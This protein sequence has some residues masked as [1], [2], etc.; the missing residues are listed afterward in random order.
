MMMTS[1]LCRAA[2][3]N[4]LL[5]QDQVSTPSN[6]AKGSKT[7]GKQSYSRSKD[8]ARAQAWPPFRSKGGSLQS[9]NVKSSV[10]AQV[11]ELQR[12]IQLLGKMAAEGT[13][14]SGVHSAHAV[15]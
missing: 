5:S 4:A 3:A 10:Q 15:F 13:E 9:H 12:K 2:S 7:Q 1:P 11:T 14:G 8:S 6:K